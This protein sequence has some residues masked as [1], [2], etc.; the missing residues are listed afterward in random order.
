MDPETHDTPDQIM[1]GIADQTGA[2]LHAYPRPGRA[3]RHVILRDT[4]DDTG[5]RF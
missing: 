3:Q 5:T 2:A 4:R 1:A